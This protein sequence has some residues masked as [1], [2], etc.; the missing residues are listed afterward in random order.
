[1]S[2]PHEAL[3][4]FAAGGNG[5]GGGGAVLFVLVAEEGAVGC[6]EQLL[7][8]LHHLL[9]GLFQLLIQLGSEKKIQSQMLPKK[10]P[11]RGLMCITTEKFT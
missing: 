2:A 5:E 7:L 6:D 9:S 3:D 4:Y 11:F 10:R 8:Q 1:L